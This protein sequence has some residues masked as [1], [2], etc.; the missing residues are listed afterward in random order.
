VTL[1]EVIVVVVVMGFLLLLVLLT[2]HRQRENARL[3]GC[4]RN[5]MQIGIGLALYERS[6]G[7]LPTVEALSGGLERRGSAPLKAVLETLALPDLTEL[8]DASQPPPSHP[9]LVLVERPLPGFLCQSDRNA[10][11]PMFLAPVSYRATTGD[12][13]QSRSGGFALGKTRSLAE[14]EAGDG[15]A[16]TAA[17]AERLLGNGKDGDGSAMNYMSVP[18]PLGAEGCPAGWSYG[19]RGDAG[20][21]WAEPGWRTT[22]YG[23]ALRPNASPSCVTE[24]GSAGYIGASS[25]HLGGV[26]VLTFDGGVRTVSPTVDYQVWKALATVQSVATQLYPPS[27]VA[28]SEPQ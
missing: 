4:R 14:I 7:F 28:P 18:G 24:D 1:P 3:V 10:F 15:L 26:N 22:L 27:E 20:S 19:W 13:P 21:S 23:H 16:F 17:F 12:S 25:G 9:G 2:V 6:Q 11:A 8:R 5:L